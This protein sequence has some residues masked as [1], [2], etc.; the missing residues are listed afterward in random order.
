MKITTRKSFSNILK[1]AIISSSIL[2]AVANAETVYVDGKPVD[3]K[4]INAELSRIAKSSP[5]ASQQMNNPQFKNQILQSIGLQ[6]AILMEGNKMG[7]DKSAA[8]QQKLQEI[9]PM[10]YAQILQEKSTAS[11][12][13]D[14]QVLAKYNEMKKNATTQKQYEV[15]HILVKDLATAQNIEAQLKKG[16]NF[17]D[18]AK[19]YSIDPGSKNNGGDLGWS[20]GSNYVPQF[21]SAIYKLQKGQ[22]TTT[23]VKTQFGYHII[24]LNDVKVG[25]GTIPPFNQVKDQI[26]QE[27]KSQGARS[28]FDNLKAQYHIE[29]K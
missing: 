10:I 2:A 5:M 4:I 14:S 11:S 3:P 28:F 24:K 8:Y 9:K 21:S 6:Q 15:S 13:T 16:A 7:L 22:Y 23:P 27:L 29:V 1:V 25:S 12:V 26:K 17:A 19:K 18:L 20:D